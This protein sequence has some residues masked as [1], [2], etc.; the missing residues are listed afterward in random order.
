[1]SI[2]PP[3]PR[4]IIESPYRATDV[5]SIEQHKAYLLHA[6][7][8]SVRRGEAPFASHLLIPEILDDDTPYERAL[9]IRC[10]LTWGQLCDKVVVCS[11]LGVSNGM[12][13]AIAFYKEIGK[14]IEWRSLPDRIVREVRAMGDLE[15]V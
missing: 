14:P 8:D 1:M 13:Q 10:G 11:D 7:A 9:G 6:L 15:T 2:L 12:K 5:Y 3:Q 4:V